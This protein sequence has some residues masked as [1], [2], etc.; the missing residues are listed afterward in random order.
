[1]SQPPVSL[2]AY[3][4][5]QQFEPLIPRLI[6]GALALKSRQVVEASL[7]LG[8]RVHPQTAQRLREL[9]RSMNSYYSNRIE[10]Q[11]TH[12]KN[13]DRAL[14][15][16]FSDQADI[17]QRQRIALAHI[18]AEREL[19]ALAR[20]ESE[21]LRADFLQRAHTAL[22]GR[23]APDDRTTEDGHLVQAGVL[24]QQDVAVGRHQPP[25]WA[26][27]PA[28]LARADQVYGQPFGLE[29]QLVAIACAHHRFAWVHPFRDGN[30]RACRL[31]THCALLPLSNGL[32]SVS[33]GL[34]RDR[35]RYYAMLAQAEMG[36]QGDLDGR[37]NLSEKALHAWCEYFLS[38][39]EDQ[40]SFLEKLLDLD[41]LKKRVA[42]LVRVRQ[43]EFGGA[44]Y[45][46]EAILPLQ[47]I[48]GLGAVTRA[49]FVQM[50][51]LETRTA[52]KI[53]SRLVQDGL[54]QSDSHR[55]SLSID[56]PLDTLHIL[57]PSLYPEANAAV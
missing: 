16:D 54:L 47:H 36:R 51:G 49:D 45:R 19:E 14:R 40:V 26:A 18:H 20:P 35:E 33:R 27:V 1:M 31:Q 24:R 55:G 44:G 46:P 25:T 8:G 12:P 52:Q 2:S 57:F 22:Y 17:A 7:R 56:F 34:A 9:V 43:E 53:I 13:I 28:F 21:V 37:G 23:L 41:G 32:W 6:S 29:Q 11:S 4:H 5:P 38:V 50:T 39:C 15:K 42:S 30:G 10:G 48:L 3:D